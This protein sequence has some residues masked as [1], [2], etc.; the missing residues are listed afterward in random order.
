MSSQGTQ[1]SVWLCFSGLVYPDA[2]C[3]SIHVSPSYMSIC[4]WPVRPYAYS[5]IQMLPSYLY[6][7]MFSDC[8]A[9]CFPLSHKW[10]SQWELL[11]FPAHVMCFMP[12]YFR[13]SLF[14]VIQTVEKSELWGLNFAKCLNICRAGKNKVGKEREREKNEKKKRERERRK[15]GWLRSGLVSFHCSKCYTQD[16]K[17]N[18]FPVCPL[19]S[20]LELI[21]AAVAPLVS[22]A[23]STFITKQMPGAVPF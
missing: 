6:I 20:V 13:P 10:E 11:R 21:K 12:C 8:T 4:F 15:H 23:H 14:S 3:L 5:Y 9:R 18:T 1:L 19:L 17:K 2:S 22:L 16:I 7:Q